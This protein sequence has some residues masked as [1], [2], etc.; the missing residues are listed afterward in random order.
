MY[1]LKQKTRNIVEDDFGAKHASSEKESHNVY[2]A[3]S[4]WTLLDKLA[5]EHGVSRNEVLR[6]ILSAVQEHTEEGRN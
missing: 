1:G 3:Q 2:L 4:H 6:R 5:E